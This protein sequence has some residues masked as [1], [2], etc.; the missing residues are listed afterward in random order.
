VDD[1]LKSM[2]ITLTDQEKKA[3]FEHLPV[4]GEAPKHLIVVNITGFVCSEISL[5]EFLIL[6]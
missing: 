3:L 2:D 4:P 5:W 1:I 6:I